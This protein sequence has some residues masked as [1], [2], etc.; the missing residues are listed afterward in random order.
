[1]RRSQVREPAR[2]ELA[3]GEIDAPRRTILLD[4]S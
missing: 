1:M 3:E 2:G 4:L